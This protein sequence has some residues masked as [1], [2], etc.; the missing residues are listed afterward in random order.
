MLINH[1]RRSLALIFFIMVLVASSYA[2]GT[3]VPDTLGHVSY[4]GSLALGSCR[5][6]T[7]GTVS[8]SAAWDGNVLSARYLN[9]QENSFG[10]GPALLNYDTPHESLLQLSALYGWQFRDRKIFWSV[11]TGIAYL[12]GIERGRALS[13][14]QF[15]EARFSSVGLPIELRGRT[16]ITQHIGLGC[17]GFVTFSR[18]SPIFGWSLE[19]NLGAF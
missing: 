6:G 17:A 13:L 19:L 2:Q 16:D 15:E 11:L 12:N 10:I 18:S 4:W 3:M 7:A 5:L 14:H 8:F 9:A 1:R